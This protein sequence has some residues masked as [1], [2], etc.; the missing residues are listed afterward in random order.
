MCYNERELAELDRVM[1]SV[2]QIAYKLPKGTP[3]AMI[4]EDVAY[5]GLG[6]TSLT[7]AYTAVAVKNLTHAL[8]EEGKRG[9]LTRA[10]L[11]AQV[12]AYAKPSA[13]KGGWIPNYALRLRQ[14]I[15]GTWLHGY[16]YAH[17][18]CGVQLRK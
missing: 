2:V 12:Q 5:G 4:R 3:T 8:A 18:I 15:Q 16:I 1:D 11:R 13:E 9:L 17:T 6:N 7:V 14:L 10:L